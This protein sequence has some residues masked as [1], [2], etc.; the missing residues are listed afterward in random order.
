LPDIRK[1]RHGEAPVAIGG[2]LFRKRAIL[3]AHIDEQAAD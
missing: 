1:N 3:G 2:G